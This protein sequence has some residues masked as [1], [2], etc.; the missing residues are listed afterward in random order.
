MVKEIEHL[1]ENV[2]KWNGRLVSFNA[3][4]YGQ[5]PIHMENGDC[6]EVRASD[7]TVQFVRIQEPG[8]FYQNLTSH[9]NRNPSIGNSS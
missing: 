6:V 2:E 5:T 4:P 8:Y 9:M 3:C 7:H 1:E